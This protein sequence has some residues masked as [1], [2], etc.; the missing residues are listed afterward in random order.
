MGLSAKT[1]NFLIR[2]ICVI[3]TVPDTFQTLNNCLVFVWGGGGPYLL[4][5]KGNYLVSPIN[6]Y[7][8]CHKITS[9]KTLVAGDLGWRGGSSLNVSFS[10]TGVPGTDNRGHLPRG[11]RAPAFQNFGFLGSFNKLR[12]PFRHRWFRLFLLLF[13]VYCHQKNYST[14]DAWIIPEVLNRQDGWAWWKLWEIKSR[15]LKGW[16]HKG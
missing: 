1:R 2:Q 8:E 3:Q 11:R 14:F 10:I 9:Y 15:L 16:F 5:I 13:G 6:S 7:V 4:W 12:V